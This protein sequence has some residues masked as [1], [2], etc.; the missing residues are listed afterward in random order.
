MRRILFVL[1]ILSIG[2]S[3][4]QS[5]SKM[6]TLK[7]DYHTGGL[8]L[9][10]IDLFL[11][12]KA[13][14]YPGSFLINPFGALGNDYCS[15]YERLSGKEIPPSNRT[16]MYTSLPHLGFMYVM[17]AAGSQQLQLN[18]QQY[19]RRNVL[20]NLNYDRAVSTGFFRRGEFVNA[21]FNSIL[22]Y[23]GKKHR[24]QVDFSFKSFNRS[25]NGGLMSD[26]ML[27]D[28]GVEFVSIN[29]R[30]ASDSL[31][32]FR[33]SDMHSYV[34]KQDSGFVAGISWKNSISISKRVYLELDSIY[35]R[36]PFYRDSFKIRDIRSFSQFSS[37]ISLWTESKS[38]DFN[39]SLVKN[40]WEYRSLALQYRNELSFDF[41]ASFKHIRFPVNFSSH[42]NLIGVFKE[43]EFK[44]RMPI[45]SKGF[46]HE[47]LAVYAKLA[48]SP[49]QRNYWSSTLDW[50][51]LNPKLQGLLK[52]SY[53]V[54]FP[55]F[56]LN[57]SYQD[58]SDYYLFKSDAWQTLKDIR[59]LNLTSG[60]SLS[61]AHLTI[62]PS[63]CVNYLSNKQAYI[64][65]YDLRSR[66][67]WKT[68]TK[69]S[70]WVIGVDVFRQA[71]YQL[72]SYNDR[73]SLF[74]LGD[75]E[76]TIPFTGIDAFLSLGFDEFRFF[77]KMENVHYYW[78]DK[79]NLIQNGYPITPRMMRL[80]MVWDFL[81]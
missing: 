2:N 69:T 55:K 67:F 3:F 51:I 19:F 7:Y 33:V 10:S 65:L 41:S 11:S 63:V 35:K 50:S 42:V 58:I 36:Y 62:Q 18:Y 52:F 79:S 46:R 43:H 45:V 66:L 44:L 4:S 25:L 28:Y 32:E 71:A 56:H 8:N 13:T 15:F 47:F 38:W 70:E 6:D 76:N 74:T 5:V 78:T 20:L 1:F 24:H 49:F 21:N 26:S 64:P 31:K 53:G 81:D 17:G 40:F 72:M 9:D 77:L 57:L 60:T 54:V 22:L 73:F 34:F 48:P 59:F 23:T 27:S 68:K 39:A 16:L 37:R 75:F 61:I 30:Q 29:K 80:G 12:K 14:L